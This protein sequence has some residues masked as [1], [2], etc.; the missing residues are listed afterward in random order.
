MGIEPKALP[1]I[2]G[3]ARAEMEKRQ[4]KSARMFNAIFDLNHDGRVDLND[5]VGM[6]GGKRASVAE[7]GDASRVATS[8]RS[9]GH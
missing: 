8:L 9:G 1:D 4:P 5:L 6:L 3:D 7:S 2:L